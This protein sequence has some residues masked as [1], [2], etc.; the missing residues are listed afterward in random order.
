MKKATQEQID[1]NKKQ[2]LEKEHREMLEAAR[3]KIMN[4]L[5]ANNNRSGE[6]A[7]WELLQNARDLSDHAVVKIKLTSDKLMFS[8]K[9]EL[10]TQDT[11]TR[12]IKQQSSKDENDDKVGQFGTGFMT[13]HV[14]NRK[15]YITG[16]CVVPLAEDKN[17]YVSLPKNFCLDRSSD[18]K[19]VFMEKMDEEL[20][21]ADNL[22]EQNGN[23]APS[24]E[25]TSFT[26]K[27]ASDKVEKVSKQIETTTKLMP[28]VIVFNDHIESVEIENCVIGKKVSY[29]TKEKRQTYGKTSKYKVVTTSIHVRI[30]D[31]E[32][33]LKVYSIE[34]LDGKDRI[35]IPPLPIGLDDTA[36][37]PSNFL[38]FPM[39]GSENFGT[40]FIF[41][42]SR[43]FPTEPRNSFLLP[44]DN[45]NLSS[46][47]KHNEKVL[48]EMID[49]L[50][51][52]Y[53]SN[54]SKQNLP[55]DF[56]KV[57]F[58]YNGDDEI[59]KAFYAMMQNKFSDE[60]VGWKMIPTEE[61]FKS[62]NDGIQVLDP[63]IYSS[64]T[65]EQLRK[66]IPVV[67]KYAAQVCLLPNKDIV[68]WSKVV[69][70]WKPNDNKYYVTLDM[71]CQKIK[72]NVDDLYTFLSFLKDL[73]QKGEK[74]M[75]EYPLIP[76]REGEL[77]TAK[78]LRDGKDITES[79]YKISKG[80]LGAELDK[81]VMPC[82][83]T[84]KSLSEY[85]RTDL[86]NEIIAKISN[87]RTESLAYCNNPRLLED[88]N[89]GV[90]IKQLIAYCSA[91]PDLSKESY[92]SEL[93]PVI[94][95]L[96]C[97]QY[98]PIEIP[99]IADDENLYDSAFNFLLDNTMM[100]V[101]FKDY[102]WVM[103]KEN[104]QLLL[105][106]VSKIAST[107]DESR[108][109]KFDKYGIFPNQLGEL[110]LA[111]D[112]KVNSSIDPKLQELYL[113]VIGKD[114]KQKFVDDDFK[115]FYKFEDYDPQKVGVDIEKKLE[116]NDYADD[117]VLTII[118][119]LNK[120]HWKDYF[121]TIEA[122]KED[123][124]YNHGTEEDKE[125]L[126]RI[127]MQ[128]SEK[129][130]SMATLAES[131]HFEE[132]IQ[133]A[134]KLVE[135]EEEAQRQFNFTFTIGKLIEDEIRKTISSELC[136][137]TKDILTE[138]NQYGQD[139]IILYKGQPVYYI[140]CKAK[141]NFNEPAH[142][143]SL[144]IKKAVTESNR[145]ALCCIDCTDS[146]CA[147]SPDAKREEVMEAHNKIV[148]H[149]HVHTD[150]GRDFKPFLDPLLNE[151]NNPNV[152]DN[153]SIRVT[154]SLSCNIPKYKFVNGISFEEFMSQLKNQL[155]RE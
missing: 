69:Y 96:Y 91:Y 118:R 89:L 138:D 14:F 57:D 109:N 90:N 46:K 130:K 41:H 47:Y 37:I 147:I 40:N 151:E 64:L 58:S 30:E 97:Q 128:G 2:R 39:L 32:D 142:M 50:F 21:V 54:E 49:I 65:E 3:S 87:L 53:R 60:F 129:L 140:E 66:Y 23:D 61:G 83:V 136:C 106:F 113:K 7:I 110:C 146:G 95:Q 143:S 133:K 62:L 79:L 6:R 27:L 111:K 104:H 4:G 137:E 80:L 12:L 11:L 38:Y 148:S 135:Q 1:W 98:E 153:N 44:Q 45:D 10:F 71:I 152:D 35:I 16:D 22:V 75:G 124:F 117:S 20:D 107:R 93:L 127:Q 85:T 76:N 29:S 131:D 72:S 126:Y 68:E 51:D 77:K 8:H 139:I 78:N 119:E 112:L 115:D 28:F 9:G 24:S 48:V 73:G 122:K 36:I 43:L 120:G 123:L 94:C 108:L 15:V 67:E 19:T 132:I 134:K 42:S 18:D 25:W 105:D 145:Y 82:F 17:M 149:I 13:T 125:A 101:S 5:A 114:L 121:K 86:R 55:L 84:I 155:A 92:R 154:S 59:T 26:Y 33:M 56:A 81:L 88:A 144:Q 141:W 102:S 70:G 52:Y 100:M 31:T 116:A 103:N 74:L 63:E 34:S 150:I 99:N